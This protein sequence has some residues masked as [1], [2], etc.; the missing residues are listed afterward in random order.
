[1]AITPASGTYYGFV[2]TNSSN[3][4]G[5]FDIT[6]P[7]DADCLIV[8]VSTYVGAANG[9][10]NTYGV[11]AEGSAR[12]ATANASG[13]NSFYQG[14]GYLFLNPPTGSGVTIAW[15]F[16]GAVDQHLFGWVAYKGVAS[17]RNTDGAQGYPP[18]SIAFT[19]SS[20]DLI[21][22]AVEQYYDQSTAFTWTNATKISDGYDGRTSLLSMADTSPADNVT[23]SAIY[24]VTCDGGLMGFVLIPKSDSKSLP[25]HILHP[26]LTFKPL[27]GR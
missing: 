23:I 20:G 7:A 6:V 8:Y 4:T 10:V 14:A 27:L 11:T 16:G 19:A 17:V 18:P 13:S 5:S 26:A 22:V 25:P 9:L 24:H 15:S 12:N 1:M 3:V 21:S 2:D